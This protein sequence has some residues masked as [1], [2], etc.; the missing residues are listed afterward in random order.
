MTRRLLVAG[1]LVVGVAFLAGC[2]AA[3]AKSRRGRHK[4]A[5]PR[6]YMSLVNLN[7]KE[8]LTR[9]WVIRVDPKNKN[10][11][12][13]GRKARRR[14][15]R[16]LRDWRTDRTKH[17]PERLLWNLYLVGHHFDA[18]I[19]IVSGFRLKERRTSRHRQGKAVDFRVKGVSPRRVWAYCKR[20]RKVGLGYYP[21]SQF[22]HMDTRSSSYYWIDDSGPGEKA[23][24]RARVRQPRHAKNNGRGRRRK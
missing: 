2:A 6:Y 20:F 1:V 17:I 22:V 18:P 21:T 7:T 3:Q 14:L 4:R 15:T 9:L 10:R 23:R 24:Y 11:Q 19:E 16:F 13:V 8:K 5:I 12:W